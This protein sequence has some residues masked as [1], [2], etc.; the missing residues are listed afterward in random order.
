MT[1]KFLMITSV[2]EFHKAFVLSFRANKISFFADIKLKLEDLQLTKRCAKLAQQI[3]NMLP[4][5][6]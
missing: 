2:P 3:C 1:Y 5:K 6:S 4:S